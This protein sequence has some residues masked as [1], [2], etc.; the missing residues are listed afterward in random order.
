M[1]NTYKCLSTIPVQK[2]RFSARNSVD[3]QN[4]QQKQN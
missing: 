4:A 3:A 1:N 2:N